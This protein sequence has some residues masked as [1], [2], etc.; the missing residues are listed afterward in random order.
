MFIFLVSDLFKA[1]RTT[2]NADPE[3]FDIFPLYDDSLKVL[4]AVW[5]QPNSYCI[6]RLRHGSSITNRELETDLSSISY[7]GR[8]L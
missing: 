1:N 2:F 4:F 8:T 3:H 5:G 6:G 7:N